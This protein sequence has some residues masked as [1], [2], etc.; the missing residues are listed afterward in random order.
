MPSCRITRQNAHDRNARPLTRP[1]MVRLGMDRFQIIGVLLDFKGQRL[2]VLNFAEELR[3]L[4]IYWLCLLAP[5]QDVDE[6]I[7]CV[8]I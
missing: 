6:C 7:L 3:I 4:S 8:A 2:V 5:V 1:N